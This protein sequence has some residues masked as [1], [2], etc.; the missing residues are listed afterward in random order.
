VK[1]KATPVPV[2]AVTAA[3]R[4]RALRLP[5]P[6]YPLPMVGRKA[7]LQIIAEKLDLALQ[8]QAQIIGIVA[9]AGVGKSRLAAEVIRLAQQKGFVGYGGAC[10]SDSI[11]TPYLAW[12]PIWSAFFDVDPSTPLQEQMRLLED[13]IADKV[14]ERVQAMPLLNIVLSL[15]VPDNDFTRLLEP[16]YRKSALHALLEDSLR[17]ATKEEPA[18]VVVEDVHWIDALSHDLLQD[19]A[20]GLVDCPICFVLVYRPPQLERLQAPRL[21]ALPHFTKIDL[22]ELTQ[23]EAGQVIRAKLAQLYP[24]RSK[25]GDTVPPALVEKLMARAQGN[26]F[27][28][29]E[30]LNYLHDRGLDPRDPTTLAQIELPDS[31]HT[32]ILSRIDRL[33]ESEQATLRVAS[34][35]GRLFRASWLTGYYPAL[36]PWRQVKAD[37]DELRALD[38]TP[39]D[40]P[41]PELTY[42]FKHIVT[43]EVTY[44]S[45]PFALRAELHEQLGQ[46]LER[47]IAAGAMA[48]SSLLDTLVYHYSHSANR[49]KERAY[50]AKAAQGAL[51][52]SA[53][54]PA[55]DHYA[56]LVEI[57]P[58]TDPAHS[59]L[60]L[61][62]AEACYSIGKVRASRAAIERAQATA[63][64]DADRVA[65]LAFWGEM[66][67][68]LGDYAA[69]QTILAEAVPL[70]R[71]SGDDLTLSRTLYVLGD[72]HWR[73]GNLDDAHAALDESLARARAVGDLR[74]ELY[75]LNRLA[76]VIGQQ[77]DLD[78]KERLLHQVRVRAL[79]AGNRER[80]MVALNNLGVVAYE[81]Q[82]HA[83]ARDYYEQA[84]V[85]ARTIGSQ[86]SI[87]LYLI[88]LANADILFGQPSDA[89]PKLR[90]GL[91]M[92][93]RLGALPKVVSAVKN[94]AELASAEGQQGRALALMGLARSH[95]AWS[96]DHQRDLD[97]TLAAWALDPAVVEAGLDKGAE[98]DWETTIQALLKG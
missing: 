87:A 36:G 57:T 17:A 65:T 11:H 71:T 47:Q 28:L 92:A 97:M 26:P 78:E 16:R 31:L 95:P 63:R 20:S 91:T 8:N 74:R 10:Q 93:Q 94:F 50:L 70:A 19:L 32:L 66:M 79:E 82:L 61:Q 43:H 86:H 77:G 29:E 23:A 58:E 68:E 80:A 56:R 5:E 14:P 30:L 81:R 42:I 60:A 21:E 12:R 62:L 27:F 25:Q 51:D 53:F 39:L 22:H 49:A 85:L 46:Y 37:L 34:I 41:E 89:R 3:K 88:N 83:A 69:A 67:S 48:E 1:G 90:E 54:H 52:V 75:A 9:E 59:A 35:V 73:L 2:F 24:E 55:V 98:L 64:T 6:D 44:E 33:T 72:V 15:D 4:R 96:S 84:L 13:R 45:L 76:V 18:L 40:S 7:E 38:I